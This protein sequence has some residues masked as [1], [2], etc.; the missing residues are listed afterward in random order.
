[1]GDR[2]L[3]LG[4]D[5]ADRARIG[6]DPD[7]LTTHAACLGMTGSGKTGLGIVALEEL[8]RR[9]TPLLVID[10]KGDMVN[11]L[12]NF[13]SLGASAFEP[14]L[15]RDTVA[16]RSRPTRRRSRRGCG[17]TASRASACPAKTCIPCVTV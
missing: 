17:G 2:E 15:T 9:R 3:F 4:R 5:L 16:G 10:L 7:H 8:A 14:W 12:L 1:M 11:L 6:L 13:P